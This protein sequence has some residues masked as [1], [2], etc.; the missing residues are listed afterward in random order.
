MSNETTT[1][2]NPLL[3]VIHKDLEPG[4]INDEMLK[5][6]ILEQ[7]FKG[8][9]GRLALLEPINYGNVTVLR[10][11]FQNL[12]KINHLFVLSNLK[13][14]SLKF[15]KLDKIENIEMLTKLVELDLSFN[16]IEKIGSLETLVN[17]EILSLFNNKIEK[18]E[19]LDI[20]ENMLIL[21]IGNNQINT[22]DGVI[23]LR[24][25]FKLTMNQPL[26]ILD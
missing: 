18:L 25:C 21:S 22:L 4:V 2:P 16:F 17:L 1:P 13:V 24:F 26:C 5:K 8:E 19:N 3:E 10:L 14:L 20:L 9:A 12:L 6:L 23:C 11:E 15:N 7:G